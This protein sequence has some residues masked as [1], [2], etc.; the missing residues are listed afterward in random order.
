MIDI[1]AGDLVAR[2]SP[3]SGAIVDAHFGDTAILRPYAGDENAPFNPLRAASFPMVPFGNRVA[4][5][6]FTFEGRRFELAANTD[7][8]PV[9]LHGDAWLLP[10]T[11]TASTPTDVILKVSHSAATGAPYVY[12]ARQEISVTRD[13]LSVTL[14]V[15]NAAPWPMPFGLGHHFFFPLTER[16]T[17]TAFASGFWSEKQGYLPDQLGAVPAELDFR[18]ARG[19]PARW[20]N[21]GFEGWNGRATIAWPETGFALEITA[22]SAF[23]RYFLF[24]S[25]LDFE[26]DFRSDY[27]CFEPMTHSADGHNLVDLGGLRRL[28]PTESLRVEVL[29]TARRIGD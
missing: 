24:R 10:W 27:F 8:D 11:V 21:N 28:E 5:N 23:D 12:E 9:Y 22:D 1:G 29:L 13:T 26:P 16:M 15:T 25:D 4:G 14:E 7:W 2:I 6:A 18:H 3:Q 20:I 17:L 19:L